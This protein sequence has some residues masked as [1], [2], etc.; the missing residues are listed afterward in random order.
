VDESESTPSEEYA[1]LIEKFRDLIMNVMDQDT[2]LKTLKIYHAR[3]LKPYE[4]WEEFIK[5]SRG[6]IMEQ[7]P[8]VTLSD[9]VS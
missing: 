9:L 2:I 5:D 3:L 1:S 8:S 6:D 7:C 4:S